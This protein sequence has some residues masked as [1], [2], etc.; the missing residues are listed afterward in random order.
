MVFVRDYTIKLLGTSFPNMTPTEVNSLC[1]NFSVFTGWILGFAVGW[2]HYLGGW[3]P[4]E[5]ELSRFL[6][7]SWLVPK[8]GAEWS[9]LTG[10]QDYVQARLT[11]AVNTCLEVDTNF[12]SEL[13]PWVKVV[14]RV[15]MVLAF[16]S[17]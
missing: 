13:W 12:R 6:G 7:F 4:V 10:I 9:T 16:P 3:F 5:G 2:E 1:F 11:S 15:T 17:A 8:I 14:L